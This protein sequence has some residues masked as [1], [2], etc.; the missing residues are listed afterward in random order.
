MVPSIGLRV[1]KRGPSDLHS[2]EDGGGF[3]SDAFVSELDLLEPCKVFEVGIIDFSNEKMVN[4]FV[5]LNFAADIRPVAYARAEWRG[6]KF[7]WIFATGSGK[8]CFLTGRNARGFC[9][10]N[11]IVES[12][13]MISGKGHVSIGKGEV[14]KWT[15]M[16]NE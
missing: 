3:K 2:V 15:Y 4:D 5:L 12:K 6:R 10:P 16:S 1:K 14:G 11:V 9:A 8:R 7:G 13:V